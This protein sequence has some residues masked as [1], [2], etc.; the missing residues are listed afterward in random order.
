MRSI[1][2]VNTPPS[3]SI[4]SDSGVTSSSKTSLTSP[5]STPAW[6]AAPTATTSSGFTP[7]CG[8]LPPVSSRTLSWM[9]G[10]RVAPPT[11]MTCSIS[12]GSSLASSMACLNGPTHLSTSSTVILLNSARLSVMSRCC[13]PSWVAVMNGRLMLVVVVVDSST[14]A[15]SAASLSLWSAMLSSLRSMPVFAL[16]S[17]A[18]QSIIRWSQS[19]PP[20]WVFPLVDFTSKTPPPISST[21]TSKV[22]PP[23]SKTSIVCSDS[24]SSPYAREAAVGSL[25][26]RSTSRP[27]IF[28]ASLVAWR[29]LSSK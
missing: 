8:S 27:A 7:L 24:L 19:S 23:R 14:F 5:L 3:V 9:A 1:N 21:L 26:M 16:K 4:P 25:M 2:L 11:R 12:F 6:M 18:I 28:P 15:F 17:S 10:I 20:R 29:W 22:P 13:G